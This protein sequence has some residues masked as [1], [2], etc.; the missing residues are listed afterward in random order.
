MNS[1]LSLEDTCKE[2]VQG[3]FVFPDDK[4]ND[5]YYRAFRKFSQFK[6]QR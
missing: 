2:I 4:S 5:A 6:S 1:S 3:R